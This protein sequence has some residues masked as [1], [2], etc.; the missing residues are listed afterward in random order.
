VERDV[1]EFRETHKQAIGAKDLAKLRAIYADTYTHTHGSRKMKA[2]ETTCSNGDKSFKFS[3]QCERQRPR[4]DTQIR[5]T[6][7]GATSRLHLGRL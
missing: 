1:L 7:A 6:A 4:D 2:R 3:V 5:F